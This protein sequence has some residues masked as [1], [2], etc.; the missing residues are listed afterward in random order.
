MGAASALALL[1]FAAAP[2]VGTAQ[3]PGGEQLAQLQER[4]E[5][6]KARLKLTTEQTEQVRPILR[7][8]MEKQMAVLEE[9]GIDLRG[10]GGAAQGR[11]APRRSLEQ[12]RAPG[13]DLE[14][15][16]KETR[17][18]LKD[19]LTKE[20]FKEFKKMQEEG[21]EAMRERIRERA[22]GSADLGDRRRRRRIRN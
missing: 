22:G 5:A 9:H 7:A 20:Q 12:L 21:R 19:V 4:L 16:R 2:G 3:Q 8:G 11:G 17:K 14:V 6:A 15:V 18:E 13:D 10:G 1:L